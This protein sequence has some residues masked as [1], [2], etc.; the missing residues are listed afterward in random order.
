MLSLLV[1]KLN[2]NKRT[3]GERMKSHSWRID[4]TPAMATPSSLFTKLTHSLTRNLITQLASH[5]CDRRRGRPTRLGHFTACSLARLESKSS[6]ATEREKRDSIC[7]GQHWNKTSTTTIKTERL[8]QK[9]EIGVRTNWLTL[10]FTAVLMRIKQ[11]TKKDDEDEE[12]WRHFH[13]PFSHHANWIENTAVRPKVKGSRRE[14]R[15][16]LIAQSDWHNVEW[17]DRVPRLWSIFSQLPTLSLLGMPE[18]QHS[19][20]D[21]LEMVTIRTTTAA[22][23]TNV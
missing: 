7:I 14:K 8:L 9:P 6:S 15:F 22:A 2:W 3:E 10:H 13:L 11:T 17:V 12:I 18:C 16:N 19:L 20:R 23:T 5:H 21:D 1:E 4:Y